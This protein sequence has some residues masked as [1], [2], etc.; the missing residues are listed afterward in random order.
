MGVSSR[1][2]KAAGALVMSA[3]LYV[4]VYPYQ[5]SFVGG[6]LASGCLAA[7]VGGLADW[8]AISAL[9]KRPLGIPWR[10]EIVPRN[11]ERLFKGI[12]EFTAEDLLSKKN[13][14]RIICRYDMA[15][16]L[17]AFLESGKGR[18]KV[19]ALLYD[20]AQRLLGGLDFEM[21]GRKLA[22]A[23]T[24]AGREFPVEGI[25]LRVLQVVR[26]KQYDDKAVHF[27]IEEL[28]YIVRAP[29]VRRMICALVEKFKLA[30]EGDSA[31]RQVMG[32]MMDFSSEKL[33]DILQAELIRYLTDLRDPAHAH[34]ERLRAWLY[35][36]ENRREIAEAV[37]GCLGGG[38][39][40]KAAAYL[41]QCCKM[42]QTRAARKVFAAIDGL[43]DFCI[44][45][46]K[47]NERRQAFV[48]KKVKEALL[49]LLERHHSVIV[50]LVE[51]RLRAFSNE[52]LS[53]FIERKVADD[54]QMI[55]INGSLVGALAGMLLYAAAYAAERVWPL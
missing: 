40:E 42:D 16:L 29:E 25:L 9:F 43:L 38:L 7:L 48:D 15:Q 47:E 26:E 39:A 13:I 23:F 22:G 5:S 33:A 55:R 18:E 10:T 54:L 45:S 36:P 2:H 41:K 3:A 35:A 49:L 17:L 51:E 30:Y 6:L 8:F 34:R 21:I 11:R 14:G 53:D 46:L 1:K 28:M 24:L 12:V 20:L 52:E 44:A 37:Q 27:L 32:F 4:A 31:R 19:K 50:R